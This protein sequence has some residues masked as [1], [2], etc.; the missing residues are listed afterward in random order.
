M[1][2]KILKKPWPTHVKKQTMDVLSSAHEKKSNL[3]LLLDELVYWTLLFLGIAGNFI[4]SVVLVQFMLI[5]TGIYL[6]ATLFLVGLAFGTLINV[7]LIEIHKIEAKAHIIPG[8][9]IGAIALIN[10]YIM[11]KLA[12]L[13]EVKLQLLTPSHSPMLVSV[14]YV[15]AFLIP[16][17]ITSIKSKL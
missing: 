8:L 5:L 4:I 6:Y 1:K 16:H 14:V 12:N 10:V 9:L 7:V 17:I 13:L 3:V 11:T 15:L 2:E